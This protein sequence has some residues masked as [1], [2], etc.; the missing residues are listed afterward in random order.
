MAQLPVFPPLCCQFARRTLRTAV[1]QLEGQ[2]RRGALSLQRLWFYLQPTL[3]TMGDLDRVCTEAQGIK[4]GQL[5]NRRVHA[6]Q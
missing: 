1:A 3:H 4:G 2:L 5:V 6:I